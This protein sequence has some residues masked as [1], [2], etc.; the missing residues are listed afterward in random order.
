MKIAAIRERERGEFRTAITPDIA[1][2]YV[3]KGYRVFV[4]RGMGAG[5]HYLDS[6]YENAGVAT[7]DPTGEAVLKVREPQAYTVPLKGRIEPH[8]HFRVCGDGGWMGHVKTV[9]LADGHIEGF[10]TFY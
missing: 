5:A 7:A 6:D 10:Q 9:F 3:K 4:E 8:I 1:K 2:L